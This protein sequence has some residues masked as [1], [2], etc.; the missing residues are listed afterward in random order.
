VWDC[1]NERVNRQRVTIREALKA[2]NL[3]WDGYESDATSC[4]GIVAVPLQA[5]WWRWLAGVPKTDGRT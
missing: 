4:I 1:L 5:A 3:R 2:A